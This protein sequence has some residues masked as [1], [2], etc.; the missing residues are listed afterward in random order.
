MRARAQT[1]LTRAPHHAD[2]YALGMVLLETATGRPPEQGVSPV[3]PAPDVASEPA[4]GRRERLRGGARPERPDLDPRVRV[5]RRPRDRS[6]LACHPRALPRSRP[7][8]ALP[9][10]LGAGRGPGPLAHQPASGLHGRAVLGSDGAAR[11]ATAAA[12]AAADR[13]G[14]VARRRAAH[15][16]RRLVQV[17]LEPA[18]QCPVQ[19]GPTLGRPRGTSL[20]A[21]SDSGATA[22][23]P[24]RR[25]P[26][27]GR[28]SRPEGICRT[29]PE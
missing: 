27:R 8:P 9:A 24:A 28:R 29:R 1:R 18:G 15:D 12:E 26:R 22:S 25:F 13:R 5:R 19:T 21:F 10:C 23:A 16:D 20:S 7:G 6:G 14:L 3:E 4:R 17:A 2:I 11:A